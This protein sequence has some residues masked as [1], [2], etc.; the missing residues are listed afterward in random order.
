MFSLNDF[1]I[2]II[3]HDI[4]YVPLENLIS[5]PISFDKIDLLF[6]EELINADG[7]KT[8]WQGDDVLEVYIK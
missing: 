3:G 5:L 2:D 8:K 1:V 4:G 7:L 6:L